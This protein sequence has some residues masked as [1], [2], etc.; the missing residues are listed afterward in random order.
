MRHNHPHG[1]VSTIHSHQHHIGW[2]NANPPVRKAAPGDVLEFECLDPSCGQIT[3]DWKAADLARLDFGKINPTLG[4]IEVDGAEPG[5]ALRITFLGFENSGWGWTANI[6]GFGLLADQFKDPAL[7]IWKYDASMAQPAMFGG[8]AAV[9]LKPF[10][11]TIG[12]APAEPGLHS[13]VPPRR[14]G[15]N[16]DIRDLSIGTELFLPIEVKGALFSIGDPHAAQG[17]G[18]VCGTAIESQHKVT[19]KLDLVKAANLKMPRFRTPGPVS[20]HLDEKG[21]DVTTGIA[22]D[23]FEGARAAVSG[24]IDLLTKRHNISAVEAYMLCSV[25]GDLRISEIVD[26]PNWVVSL[27]FP[28]VVLD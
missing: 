28:R 24:M 18:E 25:C 7:H 8:L 14:V 9:P 12:V 1:P 15:G 19:L 27:Y 21:Y 26:M 11:G 2:N 23:L 6:P 4:P 17:D 5:D 10:C 16:M 3:P 22:P 20:R 13:V